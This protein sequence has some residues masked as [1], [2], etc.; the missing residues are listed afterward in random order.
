M[1]RKAIYIPTGLASLA[2]GSFFCIDVLDKW[3][4]L[5]NDTR[6]RGVAMVSGFLVASTACFHTAFR[7]KCKCKKCC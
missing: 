1:L 5:D 7:K 3:D 6:I 2:F 4:Y